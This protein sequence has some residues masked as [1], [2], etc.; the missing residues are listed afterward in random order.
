ML[1]QRDRHVVQ[2]LPAFDE[3]LLHFGF[4]LG[5][6][7]ADFYTDLNEGFIQ[8]ST[9]SVFNRRQPGF[10]LGIISS[11]NVHPNIS[12]R[13]LP[14]LSFQ[15]RVLEYSIMRNGEISRL[16]KR[17]ESTFL[18]FP[19][20]MKLRTN[21]INNFAAYVV[22]GGKYAV[23]MSSQEDVK[24][25]GAGIN[26]MIVRIR[27]HDYAA[28]V[29]V[30]TDFFLPYFKFGIELKLSVGLRNSLV[31]DNSILTAPID[32]LRNKLFLL[33]FTFEG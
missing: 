4:T 17:V 28:Q 16:D 13:F 31:R 2:N 21:R 5:Y 24:M 1:A 30:G 29:G 14:A 10:N 23:D 20:V 7:N 9:M 32:Q 18:D 33:S 22:M 27:R 6:N 11:L 19:L 12:F 3:K 15:D 8:D 26:D 25:D